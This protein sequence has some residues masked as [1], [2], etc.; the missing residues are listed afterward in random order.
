LDS[1]TKKELR[2]Q[3]AEREIIGGTYLIRNT[4]TG[5]ALLD[6]AANLQSIK[7]RFEFTRSTG[8]C[9]YAKL[10][11]DWTAQ[12][13]EGFE[14]S[15]LEELQKGGTQTDKEFKADL[16]TLKGLWTE[17]LVNENLY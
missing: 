11:A 9:P 13:G 17:K 6:T 10:Q 2:E 1:Q 7:N 5:R 3:Y 14:L 12:N 16:E 8:T 15:V 4:K